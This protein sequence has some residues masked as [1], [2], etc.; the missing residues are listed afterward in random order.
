MEGARAGLQ[1]QELVLVTNYFYMS[2]SDEEL[3]E[4]KKIEE[5]RSVGAI[6]P[7]DRAIAHKNVEAIVAEQARRFEEKHGLK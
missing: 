5:R 7:Q 6:R 4:R 1:G 2:L 3:A